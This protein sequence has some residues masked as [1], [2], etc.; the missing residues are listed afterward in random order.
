[1][2]SACYLSA[3]SLLTFLGWTKM[4]PYQGLTYMKFGIGIQ[5]ILI[6]MFHLAPS[7][8]AIFWIAYEIPINFS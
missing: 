7:S 5:I 8:N 3:M 2:N 4:S 6:L 1:M